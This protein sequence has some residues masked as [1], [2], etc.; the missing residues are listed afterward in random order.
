MSHQIENNNKEKILF[1]IPNG[2]SRAER[3]ITKMINSL[4][5][6]NSIFELAEKR[7]RKLEDRFVIMQSTEE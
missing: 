2:Y 1:K 7:M 5:K 6:L 3:T 4:Q